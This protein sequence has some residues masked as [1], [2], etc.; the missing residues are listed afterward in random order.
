M[1]N[2]SDKYSD[3]E[4]LLTDDWFPVMASNVVKA[5]TSLKMLKLLSFVIY[6]HFQSTHLDYYCQAV[7]IP[8][9]IVWLSE[10]D[11][12]VNFITFAKPN[13]YICDWQRA[14]QIVSP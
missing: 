8:F 12:Q 7:L 5:R 14:F 11:T 9:C 1:N 10:K 3:N 4:L 13:S 2:L 6:I